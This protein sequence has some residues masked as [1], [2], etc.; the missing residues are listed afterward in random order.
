MYVALSSVRLQKT[1]CFLQ[2]KSMFRNRLF[3]PRDVPGRGLYT[4]SE[5]SNPCAPTYYE[6]PNFGGAWTL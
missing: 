4:P 2:A 5:G 3:R 6:H 1:S